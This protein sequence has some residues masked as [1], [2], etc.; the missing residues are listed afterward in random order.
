MFVIDMVLMSG[1]SSESSRGG[2]P[3]LEGTIYDMT[4]YMSEVPVDRITEI[5]TAQRRLEAGQLI[6]SGERVGLSDNI[7]SLRIKNLKVRAMLSIEIDQIDSIHW[8]MAF[9][10]EEFRQVR[11]DRDDARRRLRRLE[12]FVERR[13]GFHP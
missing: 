8:H 4:H 1:D 7:M 3:D 9:S 12:S 6:A 11:R 10:Q 5:E 13:L 2:I